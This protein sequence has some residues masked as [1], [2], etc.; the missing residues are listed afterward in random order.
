MRNSRSPERRIVRANISQEDSALDLL[1]READGVGGA[2][3]PN[4][5]CPLDAL[6]AKRW[7]RRV[8]FVQGQCLGESFPVLS[9]EFLCGTFEASCPLED[10]RFKSEISALAERKRF[11]R[12]RRIS[13]CASRSPR[14]HSSVQKYACDASMRLFLRRTISSGVR[15]SAT[16]TSPSDA[17]MRRRTS[18]G[19]VIWP[20]RRRVRTA[21]AF[22]MREKDITNLRNSEFVGFS[23]VEVIA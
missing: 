20:L 1:E 15:T 11:T 3:L 23:Y 13:S 6:D 2:A 9:S 5:S 14:C 12:P 16:K 18:E 8:S 7:V 21:E 10:H 4:S 19:R 22:A 17:R